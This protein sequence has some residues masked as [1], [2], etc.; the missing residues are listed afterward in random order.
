VKRLVGALLLC[1]ALVLIG[2]FGP[3]RPERPSPLAG[4][5]RVERVSDDTARVSAGV[6]EPARIEAA[7]TPASS[8]EEET[9]EQEVAEPGPG[10]W[11]RLPPSLPG[12]DEPIESYLAVG[13]DP[14]A[15][16]E[17]QFQE[18]AR[19]LDAWKTEMTAQLT[20]AVGRRGALA[21]GKLWTG[22]DCAPVGSPEAERLS[23]MASADPNIEAST[24]SV[25]ADVTPSGEAG[26]LIMLFR[27]GEDW[28]LD[29]SKRKVWELREA[30][31]A[32][33][34]AYLESL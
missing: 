20:R 7:S 31:M 28:E 18:A 32:D 27:R 30:G 11:D 4:S 33:L 5:G 25:G 14:G 29:D 19:L 16:T 26:K 6:R 3:G 8:D 23:A 24:V 15:L 34:K 22:D 9:G 21:Q 17:E 13:V 12:L 2:L 1:A 10:A